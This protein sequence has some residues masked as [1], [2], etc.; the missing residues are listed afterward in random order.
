MNT[1]SSRLW[2][3]IL[4]ASAALSGCASVSYNTN[5]KIEK[6]MLIWAGVIHPNGVTVS[7]FSSSE[8]IVPQAPTRYCLQ[9][10]FVS[11]IG[12]YIRVI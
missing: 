3:V 8:T 5:G 2:S 9:F 1:L 10:K 12:Q 11:L 7:W 4:A 6:A